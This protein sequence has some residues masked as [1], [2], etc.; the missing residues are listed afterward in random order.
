MEQQ[1]T[2][3]TESAGG[4]VLNKT[5]RVLVVNQRG[6]SWSLP[7]GQVDPGETKLEAAIREI[8]EESGILRLTMIKDLGSYSRYKIGLG[9]MKEDKSELK[10]IHMFLF[11]T[12]ETKLAPSDPDHPEA[13]WVH[14][15]D[16]EGLLTHP[17]DKIFYR[18]VRNQF[19]NN[20]FPKKI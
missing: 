10:V 11:K 13:R 1:K 18:T 17:K 19:R 9:E 14:A 4:I 6:T 20:E 2:K 15:D 12:D 5:G 8:A 7:K 16:V 3:K